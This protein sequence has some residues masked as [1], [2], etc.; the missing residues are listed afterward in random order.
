MAKLSWNEWWSLSQLSV[1]RIIQINFRISATPSET[2]NALMPTGWMTSTKFFFSESQAS[3]G[4]YSADF[5]TM[6]LQSMPPLTNQ[7]DFEVQPLKVDLAG[8]EE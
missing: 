8:E 7:S 3:S 1:N 6:V 5:S 2:F 4:T